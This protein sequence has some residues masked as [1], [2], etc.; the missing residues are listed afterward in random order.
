MKINGSLVFDA[1]SASEIQNLRI[2]KVSTNPVAIASDVGRVIYNTTTKFTYVGQDDGGGAYSWSPLATGGNAF[3]Q[4]EGDAIEASLGAGINMDGTFNADGFMDTAALMNPTSFTDA[5]Q[6]IANYATANDT[7]GELDDVQLSK[8]L[9]D[10]GKFLRFDGTFARDHTLVLADVSN[11]IA[12]ATEVNQLAGA[13][14]TKA[15]FEKLHAVTASAEELNLLDGALLSTTELNFVD[16]VTSPIQGQLDNKQPLDATL[17]SLA[18]IDTLRGI[19]V[20]S[21]ENVFVARSLMAPVAG[22]TI[23]NADGVDGNPTFALA[24]D[25]AAIEG[26]TGTGY[27]VRTGDGTATTRSIVGTA[28]NIVVMNADGVSSDTSLDLATITQGTTGSFL[29][30]S[31]DAKGRVVSNTAVTTADI[32]ALADSQYLRLDGTT[33]MTGPLNAG[34]QVVTSVA[35][36]V[37]DNDAANKAYVDALTNGLS[38]KAAV[39]AAT[40]VNGDLATAFAAGQVVDGVTLVL[41]DRILVK[42]Q[43]AAAENG[44]YVVTAGA[45]TRAMDMNSAAEFDGAAVF[46]QEGST[47]EGS[48]WTEQLTVTTVGAD[49]V[50]FTQFS[51][52]QAFIW[53]VGLEATGN[54]IN[55][56]LGSGIAELP[57]DAVG[58]DLYGPATSALILTVNGIDREDPASYAGKLALLLDP[59]GALAQTSAGLKIA[60]NSVTNAMILNDTIVLNSDTGTYALPLGGTIEIKGDSLKGISTSNVDGSVTLTIADASSSQKGVAKFSDADFAV[61]AGEVTIKAAGVGNAQLEN[62]SITFRVTDHLDVTELYSP[63]LG[64]M[65]SFNGSNGINVF[66]EEGNSVVVEGLRA[67]TTTVGVASFNASHFSVN[68]GAVS[69]AATLGDLTNVDSTVDVAADKDL[70]SYDFATSKWVKATRASVLN[71]ESINSLADVVVTTPAVG[72]VLSYTAGGEWINKKVYHVEDVTVAATSWTVAHGLGTKY[73]NVT[74]VDA[75]DNVVIPQSIV[76]D[77]TGQLTVTFNTA[78]TGKVVVMGIA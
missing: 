20:E 53:G 24:N 41:G 75:T 3:S 70:L 9:P 44:I 37:A 33:V 11:V 2:Q 4:A 77:T 71:T 78:I 26:L 18:G 63:A 13:T 30:F 46:V 14:V 17:T 6:Q 36:P 57:N 28:G 49:P 12:T 35:P 68:T 39:R 34:N 27:V 32:T 72:Q 25:L 42:N 8:A 74:V 47:N 1:S 56:N 51:G 5:I 61:T 15:D 29:K 48:G 59:M 43:T 22:L 38:W 76:F 60:A 40:T 19:L 23:T 45:P 7:L 69:L 62:S 64:E 55:I 21:G 73:C 16:G 31:V 10:A 67:T 54:T 50:S 58:I 65:I 52:G 66:L